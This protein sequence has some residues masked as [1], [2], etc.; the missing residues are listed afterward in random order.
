MAMVP[1][2]ASLRLLAREAIDD[3]RLPVTQPVG[4]WG[5]KG[6]GVPCAI[7]GEAIESHE[8]EFEIQFGSKDLGEGN[9][10]L[11][12]RCFAAWEFERGRTA[13]HGASNGE[14]LAASAGDSSLDADG[15]SNLPGVQPGG[16]VPHCERTRKPR[17][18][19]A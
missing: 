6:T 16:K 9:Q 7:C 5:G 17:T 2:E 11:H 18:G 8:T 10:R 12:M 19:S 1:S 4:M 15:G 3:G 13:A 14:A